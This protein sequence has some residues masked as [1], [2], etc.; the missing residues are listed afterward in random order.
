MSKKASE[1]T[2]LSSKPQRMRAPWLVHLRDGTTSSILEPAKDYVLAGSAPFCDLR[3]ADDA[4]W[5]AY[6][7]HRTPQSV[8]AWP[9]VEL[10]DCF[11]NCPLDG[12]WWDCFGRKLSLEYAASND[13]DNHSADT[14][15]VVEFVYG[16]TKAKVLV[17]Q[18]VT[19]V[20]SAFPSWIRLPGSYLA[21]S[22]IVLI[23]ESPQLR[24]VALPREG[25]VSTVQETVI[26]PGQEVHF[27]KVNIRFLRVQRI[28]M[29][30]VAAPR[31]DS[32]GEGQ[33]T[34]QQLAG[35]VQT[36]FLGRRA[37]MERLKW[38]YGSLFAIFISSLG[39][40]FGWRLLTKVMA[41][42]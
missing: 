41:F 4:P 15:P 39:L 9:L 28:A 3:L 24:V 11:P 35:R 29:P 34:G 2:F 21:A 5:L 32:S 40:W 22:Q 23:W 37:Q 27:K 25:S 18:R 7:F 10:G 20:G 30:K 12:R 33:P 6:Y 1:I 16:D 17:N 8:E 42:F 14:W 36:V 31:Q 26:A 19:V 38:I 13:C